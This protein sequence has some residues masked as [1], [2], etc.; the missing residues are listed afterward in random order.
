LAYITFFVA[1]L[2]VT[3]FAEV[4]PS[5]F[6]IIVGFLSG[7]WFFVPPR[8]SFLISNP[9]YQVNAAFFF[10]ISF[11]VL[12]F[13]RWARRALAGE[14][15]AR[16]RERLKG[17]LEVMAVQETERRLISQ[18]LHDEIGQLLSALKLTMETDCRE[19]QSRAREIV[20]DL[21]K[22]VQRMSLDLRPAMLDDLG[23]LPAVLW[24]I[25]QFDNSAG[26]SI[27]F[28]HSGVAKRFAAELETA[29]FRVVQ[30]ALTNAVRH[31]Q[32]ERIMVR[33]WAD[34]VALTV[35]VED[36]GIGFDPA[37]GMQMSCSKGLSGMRERVRLLGGEFTIESSRGKGTRLLAELP[38][39]A[40]GSKDRL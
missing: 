15:A 39:Q 18:E 7:T 4:G 19:S 17:E 20:D 14:R 32:A 36:A 29:A 37:A 28:E 11:T 5:V 13:S 26:L 6:A 27:H 2:V 12:W 38:L 22:R 30:E 34:D 1:V 35:Q 16:E 40:P 9:L 21:L 8:H 33:I 31:A 24:L 3:Q 10:L 25:E 23:L